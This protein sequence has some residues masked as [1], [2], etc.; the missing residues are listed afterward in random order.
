MFMYLHLYWNDGMQAL[1][2]NIV[3]GDRG[4]RA[5]VKNNGSLAS[6]GAIKSLGTKSSQNSHDPFAVFKISEF[7]GLDAI[8]TDQLWSELQGR[9]EH[10]DIKQHFLRRASAQ[11]LLDLLRGR[12]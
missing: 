4:V 11:E 7:T 5:E 1:G 12:L 2:T 3:A 9:L 10:D 6:N 8:E